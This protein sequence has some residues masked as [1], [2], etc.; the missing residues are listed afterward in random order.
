MKRVESICGVNGLTA[1]NA[2]A[3]T[4][5]TDKEILAACNSENPS[6]TAD[7]WTQVVRDTSHDKRCSKNETLA[8]V[9]CSDDSGRTHYTVLC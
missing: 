1:M 6:G 8:P 4:G 5:A 7:G 2:C 9:I 3:I